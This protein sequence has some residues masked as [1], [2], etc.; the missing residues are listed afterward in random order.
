MI[1]T[2]FQLIYL[3]DVHSA[4]ML[5][6]YLYYYHIIS[7]Q[8]KVQFLFNSSLLNVLFYSIKYSNNNR[9]NKLYVKIKLVPIIQVIKSMNA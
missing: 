6:L 3:N 9:L 5:N 8:Y 7:V 1:I 2:I 4:C